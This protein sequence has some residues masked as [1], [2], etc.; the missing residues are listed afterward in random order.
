VAV[1]GVTFAVT[2]GTLLGILGPNGS[3]KSTLVM[4]IVGLLP[5]L[6][7]SVRV[8][9]EA[10]QRARGRVGY[11]PQAEKVDWNFPA[12]VRDVIGMGLYRP[13]LFSGRFGRRARGAVDAA[14]ARVGM[15]AFAGKQIRELSGG[16]Q[17]RVLVARALV[18]D[19]PLLLLDEPAAG[20]DAGAEEDLNALFEGLARAGRTVVVATHDIASVIQGYDLALCLDRGQVAFGPAREVLTDEVLHR[21]FGRQLLIVHDAGGHGHDVTLHTGHG[22]G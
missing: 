2:S 5:A 12:T 19:P 9:G 3:G 11:V 21:T 1:E 18:K 7:G 6:A 17:R 8:L 22:G 4:A 13:A 16:Q 20:L 15:E 14:L 10:P